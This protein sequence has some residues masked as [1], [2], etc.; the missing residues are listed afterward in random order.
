MYFTTIKIKLKKSCPYSVKNI[1]M[2]G[3]LPPMAEW[4]VQNTFSLKIHYKT[5]QNCQI[6]TFQGS[7]IGPK[8]NKFKSVYQWKTA[9]FEIQI[10]GVYDILN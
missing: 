7:G 8:S 10:V 4:R 3:G 9:K 5:G 6:Q 2:A 1:K